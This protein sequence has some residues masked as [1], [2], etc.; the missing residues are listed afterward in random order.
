[1]LSEKSFNLMTQAIALGTFGHIG[2]GLFTQKVDGHL[3]LN[4]PG[5]MLDYE[6]MMLGDLDE[7]LES[8]SCC[9][10]SAGPGGSHTLQIA[11][12]GQI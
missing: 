4:H 11:C 12:D 1:L 6:S 10:E 3:Y 8:W 2:Y 5:S 9:R 7:G